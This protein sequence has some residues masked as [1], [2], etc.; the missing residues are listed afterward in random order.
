MNI[1]ILCGGGGTR[2]WPL[3]RKS[4]PKQF[5]R[6]VN[7]YS[8]LQN[9]INRVSKV[10]SPEKIFISTN[11]AF[12]DEI[13]FQLNHIPEENIIVEPEKRDNAPAIGLSLMHILHRDKNNSKET[14]VFLPSDHIFEDEE[15]FV[16]LLKQADTFC[17]HNKDQLVTIGIRPSYPA[18]VY[19]YIK[20]K[21]K[22][23]EKGIFEVDAF[24][25]KPDIKRAEEYANS[26]EY[27]W[28]LGVFAMN[29]EG[30]I[31]LFET[32]LPSTH[33]ALQAVCD[34]IGTSKYEET[35]GTHYAKTE[36]ISI[37]YGIV[38]KTNKIA[39]LPADNLGWTDVG[40]WKELKAVRQ[41]GHKEDNVTEGNVILEDSTNTLIYTQ[42]K[43]LVAGFGLEN[44]IVVDTEDAL[45]IMPADR[46][47]EVKNVVKHVPK[48]YQ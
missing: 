2:L 5:H 9:T 43:R 48:D 24:V 8:L 45:L 27:L 12:V 30:F 4:S 38:E 32:H 7:N 46:A 15:K 31:H 41:K 37:D 1:V 16:S 11:A 22:E 47:A 18:T 44:M 42:G 3:S 17:K 33:K 40:N 39:V 26:W 20:M 21:P 36:A 25:E 10:T 34:S 14:T 35:L 6:L 28:N 23:L 29:T 19:G 13:R